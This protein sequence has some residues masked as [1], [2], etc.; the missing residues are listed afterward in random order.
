[1]HSNYL[2]RRSLA[3]RVD[4]ARH[5]V[6]SLY[7]SMWSARPVQPSPC[8]TAVIAVCPL[9]LPVL[10]RLLSRETGHHRHTP[11]SP[12]SSL[13]WL[14]ISCEINGEKNKGKPPPGCTSDSCW[15]GGC[16]GDTAEGE[17]GHTV[18]CVLSI[19]KAVILRRVNIKYWRSY[20]KN[21][22]TDNNLDQWHC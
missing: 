15:A 9:L 21:E 10:K 5:S 20:F 4:V 14:P 2:Q 7:R 1:M 18:D 11:H 8:I 19:T 22:W 17:I 12:H 3:S 13:A 16:S 6:Y